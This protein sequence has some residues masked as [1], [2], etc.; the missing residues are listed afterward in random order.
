MNQPWQ[1][2]LVHLECFLE[3]NIKPPAL[4]PQVTL[5][6][7]LPPVRGASFTNQSLTIYE[8]KKFSTRIKLT[9]VSITH[10]C[11]FSNPVMVA[12]IL[13]LIQF[14]N[15]S[16]LVTT[17]FLCPLQSPLSVIKDNQ[18]L[19]DKFWLDYLYKFSKNDN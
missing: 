12:I 17:T 10:I 1:I 9:V 2:K 19:Q 4:T 15:L 7:N 18:S 3:E 11:D 6:Q 8:V 5:W 14:H 13:Q 16:Q